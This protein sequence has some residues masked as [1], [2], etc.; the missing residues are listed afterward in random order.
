MYS[1]RQKFGLYSKINL[2]MHCSPTE[3]STLNSPVVEPSHKDEDD[4]SAGLQV[5]MPSTDATRPI[6][7]PRWPTRTFA[8]DCLLKII[9]ACEGDELHFDLPKAKLKKE[10]EK[11]MSDFYAWF[12]DWKSDVLI[13]FDWKI[14]DRH[15]F[16]GSSFT[17]D[18]LVLHL[19]ELVKM[20]FIAATSDSDKLR[21]AGLAALDVSFSTRVLKKLKS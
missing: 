14:V 7:A 20:A 16:F 17:G 21:L 5:N 8:I 12:S 2:F 4:D 18:F 3:S 10:E 11:G 6:V 19:S 9:T 1:R 15:F 13:I